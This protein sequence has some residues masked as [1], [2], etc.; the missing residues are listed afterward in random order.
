MKWRVGDVP[1]IETSVA[2]PGIREKKNRKYRS[3]F[4]TSHSIIRKKMPAAEEAAGGESAQHPSLSLSLQP[5]PPAGSGS[6]VGGPGRRPSFRDPIRARG[7]RST[8]S[9]PRTL[10]GQLGTPSLS[11]S[12]LAPR[13]HGSQEEGIANPRGRTRAPSPFSRTRTMGSRAQLLRVPG[14]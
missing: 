10:L 4:Y 9:S 8:V 12:S 2:L 6:G 13:I 5:T 14:S 1:Q 7:V 11:R 3:Y